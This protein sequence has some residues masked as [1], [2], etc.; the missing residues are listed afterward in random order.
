MEKYI[1]KLSL[2]GLINLLI[3]YVLW[4]STFLAIRVAVIGQ[5][6]IPPFLMGTGRMFVAGVSLLIIGYLNKHRLKP[7]KQEVIVIITSSLLIW[8][9]GTALL[10]WGM[11]HVQSVVAALITASVPIFVAVVNAILKREFPSLLL[12]SSLLLGFCG[13]STIV[14]PSLVN[15]KSTE[16]AALLAVVCSAILCAVGFAIQSR[17]TV[18]LSAQIFSGYQLLAASSIFG[19]LMLFNHESLPQISFVALLAWG[20]LTVT[21]GLGVMAFAYILKL[22]PINIAMTY[23]YVNPVLALFWGWLILKEQVLIATL[24]GAVMVILAVIGVFK[25]LIKISS[26][27]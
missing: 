22:L 20:Y 9:G 15:G 23:A 14:W 3:V 21:T 25:D 27:N 2:L 6:G 19:S 10:T 18:T 8:G 11:Q 13:L 1:R 26:K 16:M 24:L 12:T 7:S 4:S 5:D 17:F